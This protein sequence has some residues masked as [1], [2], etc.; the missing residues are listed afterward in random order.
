MRF[1]HS[2]ISGF[3]VFY[4]KRPMSQAE[5]KE[6]LDDDLSALLETMYLVS[7][8]GFVESINQARDEGIDVAAEN[9]DW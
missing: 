2:E 6:F 9:L 4:S 7:V 8:P 5:F 1:G 3:P